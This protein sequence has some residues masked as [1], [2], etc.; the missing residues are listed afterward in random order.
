MAWYNFKENKQKRLQDRVEELLSK[1]VD[2]I[3]LTKQPLADAVRKEEF[4][5]GSVTSIVRNPMI[6]VVFEDSLEKYLTDFGAHVDVEKTFNYKN[7]EIEKAQ[8]ARDSFEEYLDIRREVELKLVDEVIA[9]QQL[10]ESTP[11]GTKS[12][13]ITDAVTTLVEKG[14]ASFTTS[15]RAVFN[16]LF[17][18]TN[19]FDGLEEAFVE[20]P[21]G[22]DEIRAFVK[23]NRKYFSKADS[24]TG[25]LSPELIS[26][27]RISEQY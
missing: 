9:A 13:D 20:M 14:G 3:E 12:I 19:A 11:E 4:Q 17:Y 8:E 18:L 24:Y 5:Y 22:V 27:V 7:G 25:P 26:R 21:E 23:K 1:T 2:A 16:Q 6:S 10:Y 15:P